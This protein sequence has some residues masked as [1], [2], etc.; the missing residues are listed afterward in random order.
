MS[1]RKWTY[2]DLKVG[3][4]TTVEA[5]PPWL[6]NKIYDWGK[7]NGKRFSLRRIDRKRADSPVMITRLK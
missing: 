2:F 5:M 1:A 7:A 4:S 6:P 3:R